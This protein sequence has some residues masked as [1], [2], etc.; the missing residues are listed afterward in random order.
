MILSATVLTV[1]PATRVSSFVEI[2]EEIVTQ[3]CESL[4][5]HQIPID[6]RHRRSGWQVRQA[7]LC[8]SSAVLS[9]IVRTGNHET[10]SHEDRY[11]LNGI[12]A[13]LRC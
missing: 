13:P 6:S 11:A 5:R 2:D 4:V 8:N 9:S 1:L 3:R 12:G 10:A 7:I